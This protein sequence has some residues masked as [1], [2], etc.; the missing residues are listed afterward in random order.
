VDRVVAYVAPVLLGAGR[1]AL[2]DAGISTLAEAIRL[3]VTEVARV[4]SDLRLVGRPVR[5]AAEPDD[6]VKQP[7]KQPD[8]Q[9][10]GQAD[11]R[12]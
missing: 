10:T 4:G 3:E 12:T 6:Q 8:K 7:D 11:E 9:P 2:D 5:A 1:H